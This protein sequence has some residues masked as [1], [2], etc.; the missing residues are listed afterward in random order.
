ME[1]TDTRTITVQNH[2][3]NELGTCEL[4]DTDE[5]ICSPGGGPGQEGLPR[6]GLRGLSG[7]DAL[8]EGQS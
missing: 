2:T 4:S 8:L 1:A 7:E 5:V 3:R 6:K